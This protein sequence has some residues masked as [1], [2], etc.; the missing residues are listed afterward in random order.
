[1]FKI[2]SREKPADP[3]A[4]FAAIANA[5]NGGGSRGG[6]ANR[7]CDGKNETSGG[8]V[9]EL[10]YFVRLRPGI[11]S[12]LEKAAAIYEVRKMQ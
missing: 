6:P 7:T 12:F 5:P 3:G 11:A 9:R 2:H 8:A 4:T 10:H 1:M